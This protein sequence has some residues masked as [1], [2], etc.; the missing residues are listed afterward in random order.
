MVTIFRRTVDS[1]ETAKED[2][3]DNSH[4]ETGN[5]DSN[6]TSKIEATT[7]VTKGFR[8]PH[9]IETLNNGEM[10]NRMEGSNKTNNNN[11]KTNKT[12]KTKRYLGSNKDKQ[13]AKKRIRTKSNWSNSIKFKNKAS[14]MKN[15]SKT[16][17]RKHF[18]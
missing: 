17:F 3:K 16:L 8:T 13:E 6:N 10:A 18:K 12:S 15:E 1:K 2:N 11:N 14:T 4:S 5:M 9:S 7:K